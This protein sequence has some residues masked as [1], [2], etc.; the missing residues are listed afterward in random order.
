MFLIPYPVVDP[1]FLTLGPLQIRW[2][3]L[4]YLFGILLGYQYAVSILLK[5]PPNLFKDN[6][7]FFDLTVGGLIFAIVGGRIGHIIFYELNYYFQNPI[8]VIYIWKGGMSFH[9]A[10]IG[11]CIYGIYKFKKIQIPFFYL[12]DL[13]SA[14]TPIGLFLGR[15]ANFINSELV[16]KPT[17]VPW[18]MIFPGDTVPRHP[19]QLYEAFLEGVLLLIIL[20]VCHRCE[21]IRLKQGVLFGIFL[22]GYGFFRSVCEHFREP[23]FILNIWGLVTLT[24]GQVYSIPMMISG[25]IIGGVMWRQ[26]KTHSFK[27]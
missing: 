11:A 7:Q 12:A 25:C 6:A 8:E 5:R 24:S 3:G 13:F 2:Y 27:S 17:D 20:N 14:F 21:N 4:A 15:I 16:G 22:T 10:F 18:A 9:G 1:V 26:S 23:D 19:S